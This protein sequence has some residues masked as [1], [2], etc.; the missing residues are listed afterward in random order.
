MYVSKALA[1][2]A[3]SLEGVIQ[4]PYKAVSQAM[5][6]I[7]RTLLVSVTCVG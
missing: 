4:F 3:K 6:V 7:P 1:E 2:K 5:E